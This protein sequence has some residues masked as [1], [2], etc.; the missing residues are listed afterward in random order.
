MTEPYVWWAILGIT[1]ATFLSRSSLHVLGHR[2]QVPHTLESALRYAPA[3][4]LAAILVPDLVFV[5][6]HLDLS[7]GNPRWLAGIVSAGIF[8]ANRSMIASI[9][10]GMAV[11][12]LLRAVHGV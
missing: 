6:G 2:L 9:S 12:W 4:A 1:F 5:G 8:A 3:C 11:F 7:F 10:G